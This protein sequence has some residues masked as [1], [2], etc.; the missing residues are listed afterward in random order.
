MNFISWA[1]R[2]AFVLSTS[3]CIEYKISMLPV[4]MVKCVLAYICTMYLYVGRA[5]I[6]IIWSIWKCSSK[7]PTYLVMQLQWNLSSF[8]SSLTFYLFAVIYSSLSLV[9][10]W[11]SIISVALKNSC[12]YSVIVSHMAPANFVWF[13][14]HATNYIWSRFGGLDLVMPS[15]NDREI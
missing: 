14:W 3:Y 1:I 15:T 5:K 11:N 13:I 10:I 12:I 4:S 9:K 2:N 7:R 8:A 6:Y